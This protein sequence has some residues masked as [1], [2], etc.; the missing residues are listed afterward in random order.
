MH[1]VWSRVLTTALLI[2]TVAFALFA[3]GAA[4]QPQW[5][6]QRCEWLDVS[7]DSGVSDQT[8]RVLITRGWTGRA[9]DGREVLYSPG[10]E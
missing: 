1:H 4:M 6:Q 2:A 9:G 5:E 3:L 10:C 7:E 8:V